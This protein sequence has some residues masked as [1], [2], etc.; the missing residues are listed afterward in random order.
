VTGWTLFLAS[1]ILITLCPQTPSAYVRP[2]E[3]SRPCEVK[4]HFCLSVN[5]LG[6]SGRNHSDMWDQPCWHEVISAWLCKL[7]MLA[8]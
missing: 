3:I 6:I 8:N 4:S 7:S 5:S 1:N 2:K